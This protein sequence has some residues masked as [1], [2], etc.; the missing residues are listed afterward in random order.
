M[1]VP[2]NSANIG[3]SDSRFTRIGAHD[4]LSQGQS[5]FRLE[6]V[7]TA[8]I[9]CQATNRP[10]VIFDEV[11]NEIST[12]DGMAIACQHHGNCMATS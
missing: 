12:Y 1:L 4:N 6:L 5:T 7:E 3:L 8:S 9:L 2:A 11:G 10:L